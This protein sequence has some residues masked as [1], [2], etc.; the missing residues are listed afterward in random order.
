MLRNWLKDLWGE[1]VARS[2]FLIGVASNIITF[3]FPTL[4]AWRLREIAYGLLIVGFV[5]ANFNV[6]KKQIAE[7]SSDRAASAQEAARVVQ[8]HGD[9]LDRLRA[10]N[11][12]IRRRPYSEELRRQAAALIANLSPDGRTLLRHLLTHEPIEI[13]RRFVPGISQEVQ[14]NQMSIAYGSG[15]V[16]HDIVRSGTGMIVRQDYVLN[17]QFRT[18]LQDLLYDG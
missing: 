17:P 8:Q 7:N 13:G 18:V 5:W 2:L 1:T 9:E 15:V 14:D 6:Y 11:A 10:E 4:Q 16:R 12:E 3:F